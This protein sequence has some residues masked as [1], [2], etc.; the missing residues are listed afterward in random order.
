MKIVVGYIKTPE[1]KAALDKAVEEC[2]LRSAELV[3]VN[4]MK[5]DESD[6]DVIALREALEDV[7]QRL[8]AEGIPHTIRELVR[9]F[10]PAEDLIDIAEE[11]GAALLVIGLRRRTRTGK[12]LLGSNAHHI[13]M[14]ADCPVLAVKAPH[15]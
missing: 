15:A 2:R 3:V 13:F 1:G 12:L 4:S 14:E 9:G 7:D 8:S 6:D 5:G 11:V 10:T